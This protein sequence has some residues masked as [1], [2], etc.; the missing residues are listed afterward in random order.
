MLEV[1]CSLSPDCTTRLCC[2][3]LVAKSCLT[4]AILWTLAHQ[5]LQCMGFPRQ[6]YW[7]GL[8]FLFPGYLPDPGIK[9]AGRFFTTEP[10]GKPYKAIIIKMTWQWHKTIHIDQWKRIENPEMN[11]H[12]YGQL[13]WQRRQG[14]TMEKRQ[15]L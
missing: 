10:P 13:I 4:L 9:S 7:S 8:S 6:E 1:L 2:C 15:S 12:T 11:L 5:A 3:C 14:C